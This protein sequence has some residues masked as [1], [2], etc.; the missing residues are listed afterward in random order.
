MAVHRKNDDDTHSNQSTARMM[1]T[2]SAGRLTV[3]STITMVT[4]P[5]CGMPAAPILA[6]V[7]VTLEN[8]SIKEYVIVHEYRLL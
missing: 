7:A 4:S 2:S 3:S 8:N 6:A 5:A 1:E